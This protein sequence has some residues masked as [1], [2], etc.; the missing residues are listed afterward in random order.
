MLW[1]F[2]SEVYFLYIDLKVN[3]INNY[4]YISTHYISFLLAFFPKSNFMRLLDRKH[5]RFWIPL[6]QADTSLLSPVCSLTK[7]RTAPFE[8]SIIYKRQSGT[9]CSWEEYH[10]QGYKYL[11]KFYTTIKVSR[12]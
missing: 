9:D 5:A 1:M 6:Y 2:K 10:I 4:A 12:T 8:E 7:N 11:T 3:Q